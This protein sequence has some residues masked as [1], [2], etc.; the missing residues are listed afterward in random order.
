MAYINEA[1][2]EVL[3]GFDSLVADGARRIP[4]VRI[5][6]WVPR[7]FVDLVVSFRSGAASVQSLRL[8]LYPPPGIRG[9]P[10]TVI[11]RRHVI[12]TKDVLGVTREG[13]G[14]QLPRGLTVELP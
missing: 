4:P 8:V 14:L 10:L 5:D 13:A 3:Q 7:V 1:D 12:A 11:G 9:F 2:L 6:L